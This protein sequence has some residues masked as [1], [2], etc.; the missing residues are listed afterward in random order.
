MWSRRKPHT[1]QGQ[2]IERPVFNNVCIADRH[3][4]LQALALADYT[5]GVARLAIVLR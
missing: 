1:V 3:H 5:V 4:W 2:S